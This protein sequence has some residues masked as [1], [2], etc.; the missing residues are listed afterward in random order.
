MVKKTEER[1]DTT[2][3]NKDI[4]KTWTDSYKEVSK[5]WEN[6][7]SK[8]YKPWIES[9]GEMLE[10]TALLSKEATPQKY[11]EFYEEWIKTYQDTFGKF[12]PI[13]TLKSNKETLEKFLSSAEESNKIYRSWIAEL[14]ENSRKTRE[15]LQGTPDP[16]KHKECYDMWMKSYEKIFDEL[17]E[18]PAQES[19]KEIF[20][21]YMGIPE[22][23]LGSFSQMSKLW[24]KSYAQ[25]SG[26]LNESM[27]KL[28]EKMAEISRGDASPEVYKEFYNLWMDTNKEIYGKYV[29]SMEPSGEMFE[30]FVKSS[31][32]YLSMY[33]SWVAALE[34]MSEKAE[35]LSKQTS[36]P[37]AYKE[38]YNLWVTTYEKAFD[39]FF[40]DMP[41][42]EGPM[43]EIMDSLKAMAKTYTDT[44][45]KMS[46]MWE[47][48]GVSSASAYPGKGKHT[49]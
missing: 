28:S 36:D 23:Y 17:M 33:K 14:E 5:I 21:N 48:S 31:D 43:K 45:A 15:I 3:E 2:K 13:P 40:E 49:T 27:L 37:E 4:L 47:R 44:F 10:K 7:Y 25:L 1:K 38:F 20:G 24:K 16:A 46:Q 9:A 22:I 19:I 34:K 26:P 39:S 12:Y 42:V 41:T 29:K 11:R 6:S 35:E 32:I 30:N 8:L 18:L